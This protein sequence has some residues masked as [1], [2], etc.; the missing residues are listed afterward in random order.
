MNRI[1]LHS[2]KRQVWIPASLQEQVLQWYHEI[3]QHPGAARTLTTIIHTFGWRNMKRH[4][5]R[6]EKN[7][8]I[9]QQYKTSNRRQ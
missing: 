5:D 6:H 4:V 1:K 7:C 8:N 9:F 3:L 2:Y